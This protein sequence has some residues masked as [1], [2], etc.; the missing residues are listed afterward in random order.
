MST[1]RANFE[2]LRILCIL[3][4]IAFHC[5]FHGGIEYSTSYSLC[6]LV[7]DI[8]YHFGELGVSCFFLISGYFLSET[9]FKPR[10]LLLLVLEIEFYVVVSKLILLAFGES[11]QWALRDFFP[12]LDDG[13]WFIHVYLLIYI[14]QP[15]LKKMLPVLGQKTM[16]CLLLSQIIIW[17]VLPTFFLVPIFRL[18]DTESIPYYS[19][20]VW[21][22]VVYLV[23]YYIRQYGIP[24]PQKDYLHISE[25]PKWQIV[26][27]PFVML[28]L[29]ILLG[30]SG[31]IPSFH[32]TY[33][34]TPNSTLMLI[35]SI[36]LFCAFKD[37][38]PKHNRKWI[39]YLASCSLG[40]YLLHD[41]A[42]RSFLW[43]KLLTY[44]AT[45]NIT[46]YSFHLLKAVIVVFVTGVAIDS[47]RK[48]IEKAAVIPLLDC[49]QNKKKR[50]II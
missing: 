46:L 47:I 1:R 21:F 49:I 4:I 12:I 18:N 6:R 24:R 33:F 29:A 10:K 8:V 15:V 17:S 11:T 42:L 14:L 50:D 30:E 32:A 44:Q 43:G 16:F 31:F 41:G 27:S 26:L 35:M 13:Y 9:N 22:L 23:G 48:L 36:A 7:S 40:V 37:W 39:V 3:M 25:A 20:Y 19:R 2:Y 5:V 28:L 34:W 45:S 38:T